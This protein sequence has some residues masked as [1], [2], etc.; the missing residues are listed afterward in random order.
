MIK[1]SISASI[2]LLLASGCNNDGNQEHGMM[3]QGGM[4]SSNRMMGT[5][6]I[7]G[8]QPPQ[9]TDTRYIKGY[10]QAKTI[11]S[12]CHAMPHPNQHSSAEWP[13][14]ISRME[15]HI[16]TFHKTMPSEAELKSIVDYYVAKSE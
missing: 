14:V 16:R 8:E 1:K 4:M 10:Q 15:N 9:E 6:S 7:P 13:E 5:I 2:L 11:C 12:Q 3:G